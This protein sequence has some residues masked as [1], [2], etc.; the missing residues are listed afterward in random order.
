M[1]YKLSYT[2][3]THIRHSNQSVSGNLSITNIILDRQ[4]L[5][6]KLLLDSKTFK[7]WNYF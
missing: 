4:D 3:K 5:H 6:S 7:L 1:C 2:Y